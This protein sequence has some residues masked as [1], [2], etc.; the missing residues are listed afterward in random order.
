MGG[1]DKG[2][3]LYQNQP[4]VAWSLD[5]LRAQSW[6]VTQH[7]GISANRNL[8]QYAALGYPVWADTRPGYDGPLQ[9][10]MTSLQHATTWP[11]PLHYVL[12][13]PCDTPHLPLD[14]ALRLSNTLAATPAHL[15]AA[16]ANARTHPLACLLSLHVMPELGHYL[17][18][19]QRKVQTWMEACGV[20]WVDFD[21]PAYTVNA[22]D[23]LNNLADLT[24][25]PSDSFRPDLF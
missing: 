2:L 25:K 16:R 24:A 22:F 19:G 12:L 4:L 14:L 15:A 13:V 23:N 3:Q 6:G 1:V 21:A 20:Q 7:I 17:D 8:E 10:V 5:R 18:S 9:G 11:V